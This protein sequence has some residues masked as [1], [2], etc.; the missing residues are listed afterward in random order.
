M[1]N[2]VELVGGA[3]SATSRVVWALVMLPAS[4]QIPA[5]TMT[6][7]S[8][9]VSTSPIYAV[10][11]QSGVPHDAGTPI[12]FTSGV[13]FT[14]INANTITDDQSDGGHYLSWASTPTGSPRAPRSPRPRSP[15]R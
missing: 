15:A 14:T 7:T 8:R 10:T 11:R 1:V 3:V 2:G 5:E 12:Q 13:K 4:V 6:I 9:T